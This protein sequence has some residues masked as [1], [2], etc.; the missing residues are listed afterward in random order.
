MRVVRRWEALRSVRSPRL[1]PPPLSRRPS[2]LSTRSLHPHPTDSGEEE[3]V[4]AAGMSSGGR[5]HGW[6]WH[7]C[8]RRLG[9]TAHRSSRHP[10]LLSAASPA[11]VVSY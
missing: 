7:R 8:W 9:L 10:S 3:E 11:I 2:L 1:L 4:G 5:W 6:P